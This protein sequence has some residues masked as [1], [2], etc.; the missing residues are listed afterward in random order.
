MAKE[1]IAGVIDVV[2][3]LCPSDFFFLQIIDL[4]ADCVL[5]LVVGDDQLIRVGSKTSNLRICR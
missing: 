5:A 3:K 1:N 4:Q 2:V